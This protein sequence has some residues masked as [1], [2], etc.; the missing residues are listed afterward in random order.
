MIPNFL[1]V[2]VHIFRNVFLSLKSEFLKAENLLSGSYANRAIRKVVQEAVLK[3]VFSCTF[4]I[5]V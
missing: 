1:T 5:T 3:V 2:E 4:Q